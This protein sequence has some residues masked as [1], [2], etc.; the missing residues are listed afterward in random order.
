MKGDIWFTKQIEGLK[1]I[2]NDRLP[3]EEFIGRNYVIEKL[4]LILS[5]GIN[6]HPK[7]KEELGITPEP[8]DWVKDG[9][10][11]SCNAGLIFTH[12]ED[13]IINVECKTC[14]INYTNKY[15]KKLQETLKKALTSFS[16]H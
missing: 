13:V 1:I 8:I 2:L 7:I 4:D 15:N 16:S 14:G 10:C 5:E 11:K 6:F 12:E 3:Q 9:Y